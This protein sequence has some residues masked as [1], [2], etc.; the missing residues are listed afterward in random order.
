MKLDWFLCILAMLSDR[1]VGCVNLF[2]EITFLNCNSNEFLRLIWLCDSINHEWKKNQLQWDNPLLLD[3]SVESSRSWWL[4]GRS[5][6]NLNVIL[7]ALCSS[8]N[9]A[10]HAALS[11]QSTADGIGDET[12]QPR[13]LNGS[14]VDPP[15]YQNLHRELL[16]S[17]KRYRRSNTSHTSDL[18]RVWTRAGKAWILVFVCVTVSDNAGGCCWRRNPSWREC[19]SSGGWS[20]TRR[21]RWLDNGPQIWRRSS[22]RGSRRCKRSE[23]HSMELRDI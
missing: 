22:A 9:Y 10:G 4:F 1:L 14:S 15:S 2:L 18:L 13:K 8:E 7:A 6:L 17:H 20:C 21:R 23:A 3:G 5:C 19:W 12:V 11:R 16:L